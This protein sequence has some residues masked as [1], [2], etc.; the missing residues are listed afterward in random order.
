M[1]K[2]KK[3][4]RN[5]DFEEGL[6]AKNAVKE[7]M[8]TFRWRLVLVMLGI[9]AVLTAVYYILLSRFVFWVTPVLYT[10]AAVLFLT[11]FFVNRGFSR[12]PVSADVLPENWPEERKQKFVEDDIDRKAF[13]R[14]IMVVMVP[15]LLLV[16]VD[17]LILTVLPQFT[18]KE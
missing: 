15:V 9:F 7:Q 5:F 12:E 18:F 17:I 4:K 8:K 11:F 6:R 13:A 14:K 3:K 10:A 1:M 2:K 16:A